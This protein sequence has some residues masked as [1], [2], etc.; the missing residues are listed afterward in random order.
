LKLV[1]AGLGETV[2]A[3]DWLESAHQSRSA[4]LVFFKAHPYLDAVRNEP[5]LVN[6]LALMNI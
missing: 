2:Q 5:R 3:L 6:L 4:W 1:Y